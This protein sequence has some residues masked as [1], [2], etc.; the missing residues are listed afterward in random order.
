MKGLIPFC[1]FLIHYAIY[2]IKLFRRIKHIRRKLPKKLGVFGE[3]G[4]FTLVGLTIQMRKILWPLWPDYREKSW[5]QC[6]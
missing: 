4:K 6:S 3:F 1:A 2:E 5:Q